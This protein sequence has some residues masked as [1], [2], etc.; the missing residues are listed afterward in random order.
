M[1]EQ[2]SLDN[3]ITKSRI[4]YYDFFANLFLYELLEQKQ[5]VLL[6]QVELLGQ[7]P[8]D[9]SNIG[10]FDCMKTMLE[11]DFEQVIAQYTKVFSLPFSLDGKKSVSL[12]LSYHKEGC[13]GGESLVYV[14]QLLKENSFYL[15]KNFS[16]ENED[17]LGVLCLFMK[18]LLQNNKI[19]EANKVYK[20]C[21]FAIKDSII[22]D[23]KKF[24][25]CKFYFSVAS[26]FEVFCILEDNVCG[27]I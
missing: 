18:Q 19:E 23:I 26:I 20:D 4:L 2:K 25:N 1:I 13:N 8:L 27:L 3:Q 9:D 11:S 6:K 22:E 7:Y 14:K 21:I 16:K 15:N 12:Y 17:H 5:E 10:D 24:D